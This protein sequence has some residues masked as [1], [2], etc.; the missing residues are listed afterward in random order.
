MADEE[1]KQ[2]ARKKRA[3]EWQAKVE[4]RRMEMEMK[5]PDFI[6]VQAYGKNGQYI[7]YAS[8]SS[9]MRFPLAGIMVRIID[10]ST[11]EIL[12][13]KNNI[14]D[15]YGAIA[16]KEVTFTDPW[17]KFVVDV[18]GTEIKRELTLLGPSIRKR[19]PKKPEPPADVKGFIKRLCWYW[20]E[21]KKYR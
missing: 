20:E 2:E 21:S 8:I 4:I 15:A 13:A 9:Q 7:I 16:P 14:T 11:G 12:N 18:S 6:D 1:K 10:G 17:H 3:S 5:R 19:S